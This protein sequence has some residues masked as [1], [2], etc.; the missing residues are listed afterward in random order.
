MKKQF[1]TLSLALSGIFFWGCQEKEELAL[2]ATP[3]SAT[4]INAA[5]ASTSCC[6]DFEVINF[7]KYA[8]G[9]IVSEVTSANGVGPIGV[10]GSNP[11]YSGKNAAMIFDTSNPTGEDPDL[12]TPGYNNQADLQKVL[13]VSE[14]LN[15]SDPDDSDYKGS[16]LS[17]DFSKLGSVNICSFDVID[18]EARQNEYSKIEFFGINGKISESA[19]P[20]PGDNGVATASLGVAGVVKML[21]TLNGSGAVD[22]IKFCVNKPPTTNRGC[23]RTQGYWK[24]HSKYGPAKPYNTTW[25]KIGED[26][27]FFLSDK[28]YYQV[29]TTPPSGGNAYYILAHQYIAAQLNILAGASAPKEVTDALYQ[30]KKL[31][32]KYTPTAV[33]K[34]SK[35]HADR[36]LFISLAETL[37]KYNNGVIGPGHCK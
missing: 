9:T 4:T 34:L 14:D 25:Q 33:A 23:T 18:L 20:M 32:N 22:N 37:D 26:T 17:F 24:T 1:L 8:K 10:Y 5:T 30:A 36:K 27:K 7:N 2:D 6:T 29:I 28:T 35:S 21:I 31:F 11:K 16:S 19:L 12:K 15:T 3:V 13:I